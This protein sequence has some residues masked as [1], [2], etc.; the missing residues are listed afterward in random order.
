MKIVVDM[1]GGDNGLYATLP[2][3]KEFH[4]RH[5][6]VELTIVGDAAQIGGIEGVEVIDAKK[7]MKMDAGALEV[8][9]DKE[10][11]MAK[12]VMAALEEKADAIVSS[13]STGAFLSLCALRLKKLPGVLRPALVCDF[14]TLVEGK[15]VTLLD[16]GASSENTP[17]ELNQFA[18]IGSLYSKFANGI[19]EPQVYLLSNGTE[20]EKGTPVV[21]AAHQLLKENKNIVFRGNIEAREVMAGFADV[22]VADGYSGNVLLKSCEGTAKTMSA[23]IKKAFKKNALT[24]IGYLFAKSGFRDMA[25]T[26]DYKNTGGA[27]LLGVNAA[28]VKAHGNSDTRSFLSALEV[29]YRLS[30]RQLLAKIKEG[31]SA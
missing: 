5:G 17:E 19:E 8:F 26:M 20:E 28:A 12:A 7:I 2:A 22:I 1:M 4:K 29:A 24:M 18:T 25:K 6:D 30:S 31:L 13:G 23:L 27:L 14:P 16:I 9:R 10:T 11:S 15:K 3:V 21:K